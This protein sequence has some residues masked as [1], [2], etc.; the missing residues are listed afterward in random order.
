MLRSLLLV[1][2]LAW[3]TA[4]GAQPVEATRPEMVDPAARRDLGGLSAE[5]WRE[6]L[7]FLADR[8]RETHPDPFRLSS[9]EAFESE[10]ARLDASIPDLSSV[11]I[12]AGM[13]RVV[14]VT[15]D[16]HTRIQLGFP[17]LGGGVADLLGLR[18]LPVRLYAFEDGLTV[19][20]ATPEWRRL[21]GARVTAIGNVDVEEALEIAAAHAPADNRMAALDRAVRLLEI[22]GLVA[23]IG[24][25]ESPERVEMTVAGDGGTES[26]SLPAVDPPGEWIDA[27]GDR[28]APLHASRPGTNYWAEWRPDGTLYV[29]YAA[30]QNQ[31]EETIEAFFD[32]LFAEAAARGTGRMVLD[33]R[34]NTGGNNSLNWPIVYGLI[35]SD[36][37]NRPGSLFVLIGR[38]TFSAAQN[39]VNELERHT[40]AVFVGEPTGATPNHY[41]DAIG[42][43]TPNAGIPFFVSTLYWQNHPR[44]DRPWTPP[45]IYAPP[46]RE[47]YLAGRD[48]A[49]EAIEGWDARPVFDRLVERLEAGGVEAAFEAWRAFRADPR[50][51]YVDVEADLN[52]FGYELLRAERIDDALRVFRLVVESHPESANAHDSLGEALRAAGEIDAAIEAYERAVELDPDGFVGRNARAMLAEIRAGGSA[53]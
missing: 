32:R 7:R 3:P 17:G 30:V 36:R 22:P 44:D 15:R 29:H 52:R 34:F 53:E 8:I 42:F 49:L 27:R 28:P 50:N 18:R 11:E 1:P 39:G 26:V 12:L 51:R 21:A 38:R 31:G 35:R 40:E 13:L 19:V 24:L 14:A 16:G 2:L 25:S 41:G 9:A 10:V 33:M 47:A 45:R 4:L 6:D 37:L 23:A 48:P 20:S 5:A 43:E 46:T